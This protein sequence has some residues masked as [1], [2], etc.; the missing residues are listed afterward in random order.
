[1]VEELEE[2][3]VKDDEEDCKVKVS[4]GE[5]DEVESFLRLISF[6]KSTSMSTSVV[7]TYKLKRMQI[8]AWLRN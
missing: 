2:A 6:L 7:K 4:K 5:D 8:I 3:K 1:L